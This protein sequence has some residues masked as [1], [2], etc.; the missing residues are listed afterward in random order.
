MATDRFNDL[1]AEAVNEL[2]FGLLEITGKYLCSE[3]SADLSAHPT[4]ILTNLIKYFSFWLLHA[5]IL[6]KTCSKKLVSCS[7]LPDLV[8]S[9]T[10]GSKVHFKLLA[11]LSLKNTAGEDLA[12]DY[13]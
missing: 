7:S 3:P 6:M 10:S 8:L 13:F 9:V 1:T 5:S 4:P 11:S 12:G 2:D